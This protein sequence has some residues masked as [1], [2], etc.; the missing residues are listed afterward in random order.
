MTVVFASAKWLVGYSPWAA[1][2]P[3]VLRMPLEKLCLS[4]LIQCRFS[5]RCFPTLA[6]TI[7]LVLM[8]ATIAG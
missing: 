3:A 5:L 8:L 4:C 1:L 2:G 6:T 7:L